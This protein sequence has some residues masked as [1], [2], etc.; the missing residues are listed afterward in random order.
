MEESGSYVDDFAPDNDEGKMSESQVGVEETGS[1]VDD[2][3][4]DGEEAFDEGG[5]EEGESG[6]QK[7]SNGESFAGAEVLGTGVGVA[8]LDVVGGSGGSTTGFTE[9]PIAAEETTAIDLECVSA[10]PER[11]DTD[12]VGVHETAASELDGARLDG[13][14]CSSDTPRES[15]AVSADDELRDGDN[16]QRSLRENEN[17]GLNSSGERFAAQEGEEEG[18]EEEEYEQEYLEGGDERAESAKPEVVESIRAGVAPKTEESGSTSVEFTGAGDEDAPTTQTQQSEPY[19]EVLD[20]VEGE[21]QGEETG[22]AQHTQP[23]KND[24][25]P[26][27]EAANNLTVPDETTADGSDGGCG[28]G[29]AELVV[30][31][32]GQEVRDNSQQELVAEA[33]EHRARA[34]PLEPVPTP[35][36]VD[37]LN[38]EGYGSE[39]DENPTEEFQDD[40]E[41][42]EVDEA[43]PVSEGEAAT[44]AAATDSVCELGSGGSEVDVTETGAQSV[45]STVAVAENGSEERTSSTE[46]AKP[47]V[48]EQN[49]SPNERRRS[50]E[51][52][53]PFTNKAPEDNFEES[54]D[55]DTGEND[56]VTSAGGGKSSYQAPEA[57][58]VAPASEPGNSLEGIPRSASL[59]GQ[60]IELEV[61]TGGDS[62]GEKFEADGAVAVNGSAVGLTRGGSSITEDG[63]FE[64]D[65]EEEFEEDIEEDAAPAEPNEEDMA[66]DSVVGTGQNPAIFEGE[67]TGSVQN[68][69]EGV[70]IVS[71]SEVS[72]PPANTATSIGGG[73]EGEEE[74]SLGNG[75][76]HEE[77]RL[78]AEE[79]VEAPPP[80]E[81]V[82]CICTQKACLHG[83][84]SCVHLVL[85]GKHMLVVT[86]V[87][88]VFEHL[89]WSAD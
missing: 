47:A 71:G 15:P 27:S 81:Q 77:P 61:P 39:F 68:E 38:D 24:R 63:D 62:D 80:T 82:R 55:D 74:V 34:P 87:Y 12:V 19:D 20:G 25:R 44:V 28:V 17:T 21:T 13:A 2:F 31:G 10:L 35:I 26:S 4:D 57:G 3:A 32:A 86:D 58:K 65:F 40:F 85:R 51:G 9:E 76:G 5:H 59:P 33:D 49:P 42:S 37:S 75:D 54:Y 53:A 16:P 72:N 78:R 14:H 89:E 18:E 48:I 84:P 69:D 56:T 22:P 64:E 6:N 79:A 88:E 46:L 83:C 60:E 30:E 66:A 36:V 50:S 45:S 1:Y 41:T 67:E 8:A 29:N 11:T 73:G 43:S 52:E 23:D 7:A 70:R